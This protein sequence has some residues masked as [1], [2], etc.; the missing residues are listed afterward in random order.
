LDLI[1]VLTMPN[2]VRLKAM[3]D[4]QMVGFIA[5]DVRKSRTPPGSRRW[6]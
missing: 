2:V 4:H 1:G 6:A 3:S 5:G